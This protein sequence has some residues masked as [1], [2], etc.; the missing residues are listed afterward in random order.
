MRGWLLLGLALGIAA[1]DPSDDL[2]AREVCDAYCTCNTLLPQQQV[3]CAD[4][5]EAQ[6]I[7]QSIPEACV[8]CARESACLELEDCFDT[9]F[10]PGVP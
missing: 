3:A 10:D 2:P 8:V 7:G 5:C 1:C 9:C 6:L 4:E